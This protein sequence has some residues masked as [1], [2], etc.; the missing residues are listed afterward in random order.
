[1][2]TIDEIIQIIKNA[3]VHCLISYNYT[4]DKKNI[5]YIF[6]VLLNAAQN[7]YHNINLAFEI[8]IVIFSITCE[9]YMLS[10]TMQPYFLFNK[11][12][13]ENKE[14]CNNLFNPVIIYFNLLEKC[15]Q[16]LPKIN[17]LI[18]IRYFELTEQEI[19]KSF[20]CG[21]IIDLSFASCSNI[22]IG[23]YFLKHYTKTIIKLILSDVTSCK[24]ISNYSMFPH[25]HE[26]MLLVST[27]FLITKIEIINKIM[28]IHAKQIIFVKSNFNQ[29]VSVTILTKSDLLNLINKS[30]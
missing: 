18:L 7:R 8:Y 4:Y 3:Y 20:K 13:R 10:R 29:L 19:S 11:Y 16:F 22:D 12:R 23:K 26:F 5:D 25:E 14:E 9:C 6:L 24:K 2:E 28:V 1:M 30:Q 21:D 27:Y 15:L 17:K